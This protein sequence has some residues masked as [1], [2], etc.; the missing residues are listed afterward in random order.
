[1]TCR[2]SSPLPEFAQISKAGGGE[3]FLSSN[4]REIMTQLLVLVFGIISLLSMLQASSPYSE[5][6]RL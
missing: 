6:S 1:V 3:A 5:L 4:E 2:R